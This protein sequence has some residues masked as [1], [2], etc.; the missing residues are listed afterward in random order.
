MR[1]VDDIILLDG[2]STDGTLELARAQPNVRVFP[3][4]PRY[5]DENGYIVDFASVRNEGY[6]RATHPWILCV[7]SDEEV[8]PQ[9][10]AEVRRV[11]SGGTVGVYYVRREFYYR[12]KPVVTF[13]RSTSDHVRLF[14]KDCVRGCVKPIHERLDIVPGAFR[15]LLD[16]GITVPLASLESM[17][18][19]YD[20]FVDIEARSYADIQFGRWFRWIFLR[21]ILT[22][23]RRPLLALAVRLVPKT[24]QRFPWGYEWEQM[25]YSWLLIWKTFPFRKR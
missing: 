11:I 15:G 16:A 19:K 1:E 7:D 14:H 2:G 22:I 17:R 9:L 20:R 13:R 24:G 18:R 25:R 21:N 10:L 3:Q 5:L 4:N 8:S 12:G 23:M 6:A